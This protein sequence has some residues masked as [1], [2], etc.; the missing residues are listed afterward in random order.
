VLDAMSGLPSAVALGSVALG[1][2]ALGSVVS[3]RMS[4]S[5]AGTVA[6]EASGACS[7]VVCRAPSF[8]ISNHATTT[9]T[10]GPTTMASNSPP[11]DRCAPLTDEVRG[12]EVASRSSSLAVSP[13]SEGSV[14][15]SS[16]AGTGDGGSRLMAS[17]ATLF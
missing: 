5:V 6:L 1:A 11:R 12:E 17:L 7:G 8:R 10:K 3:G 2:V 9:T 4:G 15:G 13:V 16:V 14:G